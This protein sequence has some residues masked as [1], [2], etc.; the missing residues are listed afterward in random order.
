[1]ENLVVPVAVV[2]EKPY[3]GE[4]VFVEGGKAFSAVMGLV[5][6]G[7]LIP[8]KGP[9]FP[10]RD[11]YVIGVVKEEGF[12]GWM[13]DLHSPFEGKISSKETREKFSIGD[14]VS[15]KIF[16]VDEVGEALLGEARRLWEGEVLEVEP[17]KIPRV[18][19]KSGSMV[20]LIKQYA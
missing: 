4:G 15:A 17:A 14:V 3:R 18:I 13:V 9:Y 19:G 11:D 10:K 12:Y 5:H 16:E 6:D 8:L 1:M 7:R 2:S 20:S